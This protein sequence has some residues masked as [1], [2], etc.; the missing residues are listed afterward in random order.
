MQPRQGRDAASTHVLEGAIMATLMISSVAFIATY[1]HTDEGG[2]SSSFI[3]QRNVDDAIAILYDT[4]VVGSTQGDNMLAVSIMQCLQGDCSL[5]NTRLSNLLPDGAYYSVYLSN[6]YGQYTVLEQREP[7]GQAVSSR[8][9]LEPSWSYAFLAPGL[10]AVNPSEDPLVV[11]GLP[12]FNSNTLHSEGSSL[13]VLVNGQRAGDNASYVLRASGATRA[14]AA[15]EPIVSL[16]FLNETDE[17]AAFADVTASSL[18]MSLVP[19]RVPFEMRLRLVETNGQPVPVGTQLTLQ[20]PQGWVA[21]ATEGA[22]PD[23]DILANA[24]DASGS[25]LSS[26]NARLT[27][28]IS[29]G[30]TDFAFNATYMGDSNDHYTWKAA[31]SHGAYAAASLVVRAD[32]H[33]TLPAYEVPEVVV[34]V[35]RPIHPTA[36]TT[37]TLAAYVPETQGVTFSDKVVVN[38]VEII[39][40][41]GD[42]IFGALTAGELA[43]GTWTTTSDRLLWQGT[44][45]LTHDAPLALTFDLLAGAST[46]DSREKA[47]FIPTLDFDGWDG[48]LLSQASPG[49]YRGVFLPASGSYRGYNTSSGAGLTGNHSMSSTASY[50]GTSL[51]GEANYTVGYV[52]GMKDSLAGSQVIARERTVGVGSSVTIDVDMQAIM[53]QLGPLGYNPTVDLAVYPPWGGTTSEPIFNVTLLE[54][55]DIPDLLDAIDTNNDGVPDPTS[56]GKFSTVL[57]IPAEWLFGPYLIQTKV[58][59]TEDLAATVEG[60][61]LEDTLHRTASVYDYV[62]VTP[63]NALNPPSPLYDVHIVAWFGDWG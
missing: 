8:H 7:S 28:A 38:S 35:P 58:S 49:L 63:P 19:S 17:P 30:S 37:W 20:V 61:P 46:T 32:E 4:P 21:N 50:Q 10:S 43:G 57:D 54:A 39:D 12:V 1:D 15:T 26:L 42:G 41:S 5:L 9:L 33:V 51:P 14:T 60:V 22:N 52:L 27:S 25:R 2:K 56:I 23:W 55:T 36:A 29:G 48:R 59:W 34:T 11:Y 13:R 62:L 24:S 6:G 31:L 16:Y 44:H 47:T 3:L 45:T 18:N 40:E 53:Y